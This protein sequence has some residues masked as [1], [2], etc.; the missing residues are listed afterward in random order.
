M[1]L[2]AYSSGSF[3]FRT[4]NH[5]VFWLKHKRILNQLPIVAYQKESFRQT[6]YSSSDMHK[7]H[8]I[9]KKFLS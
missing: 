6:L 3:R 5:V 8:R 2:F 4:E 9:R 1:C 7:W